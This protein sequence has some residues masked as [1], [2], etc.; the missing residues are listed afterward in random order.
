MLFGKLKNPKL[1]KYITKKVNEFFSQRENREITARVSYMSDF[2]ND[3]TLDQKILTSIA[4]VTHGYRN[5]YVIIT[6]F[7]RDETLRELEEE[8]YETQNDKA[9][10]REL[11]AKL[12]EYIDKA[13]LKV[14]DIEVFRLGLFLDIAAKF[15]EVAISTDV[16]LKAQEVIPEQIRLFTQEQFK[17][18]QNKNATYF[19]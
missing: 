15:T 14:L 5:H 11:L 4:F 2:V 8:F 19:S 17:K 9:K 13:E 12:E 10:H 1:C 7:E 18:L 3:I 16:F 6:K